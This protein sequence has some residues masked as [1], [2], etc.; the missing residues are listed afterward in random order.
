MWDQRKHLTLREEGRYELHANLAGAIGWD[1]VFLVLDPKAAESPIGSTPGLHHVGRTPLGREQL[2]EQL[3]NSSVVL[4]V[5]N[6]GGAVRD[7]AE[8]TQ[9]GGRT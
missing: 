9:N 4:D 1:G 6:N 3:I 2:A 8:A 5:F 7:D